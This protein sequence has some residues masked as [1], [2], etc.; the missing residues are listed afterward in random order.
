MIPPSRSCAATASTSNGGG[1]STAVVAISVERSR[2]ISPPTCDS[3]S[4]HSQR[5]SSAS[6]IACVRPLAFARMLPNVISCGCGRP[7]VPDVPT[8]SA[9]ASRG[10]GSGSWNTPLSWRSGRVITSSRSRVSGVA[11]RPG[12]ARVDRHDRRADHERAVQRLGE[13]QPGLE[14][15]ADRTAP[16]DAADVQRPGR[17]DGAQQQ[18]AVGD[19]FVRRRDGDAIRAA[20]RGAREP[21]AEVHGEG[22]RLERSGH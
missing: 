22:E 15:Q 19:R 16:L 12:Q 20:P 6:P 17:A 3:G 2:T 13:R 11:L 1:A 21:V 8:I 14:R 7:V 10:G 9:T 4:G 5:S 18:L